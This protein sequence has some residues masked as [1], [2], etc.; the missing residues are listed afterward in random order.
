[1]VGSFKAGNEIIRVAV[2]RLRGETIW[3]AVL[4]LGGETILVAV[5]RLGMRLFWCF[6]YGWG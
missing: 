1:M 4:M 5:L 3:V 6:F 2:L